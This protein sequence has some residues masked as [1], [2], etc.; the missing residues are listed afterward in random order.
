MDDCAAFGEVRGTRRV[1]RP[2][3]LPALPI[4][5]ARVCVWKRIRPETLQNP[6]YDQGIWPERPGFQ[7]CPSCGKH[8]KVEDV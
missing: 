2:V 5:A 8:M 7:F 4:P 1:R 6:H 3:N